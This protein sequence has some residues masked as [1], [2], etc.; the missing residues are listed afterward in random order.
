MLSHFS[1]CASF[2]LTTQ[3]GEKMQLLANVAKMSRPARHLLVKLV[4]PKIFENVV[5]MRVPRG[6]IRAV[7]Q[8]FLDQSLIGV[9]IGVFEGWHAENIIETLNIKTLYLVD[10]Y[11]AYVDNWDRTSSE[12]L[13]KAFGVARHRL[14]PYRDKVVWVKKPSEAAAKN[15]PD[16]LDFVYIDGNHNYEFVKKDVELY[17]PK[18]KEGG[19]LGGHNFEINFMG[20]PKA[21]IEF[22]A[23]KG[24]KLEG[25][26][27]SDWWVEKI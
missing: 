22:T 11:E 1:I 4:A 15:I 2:S 27:P 12:D 10:P 5:S 20:V 8:K 13:T 7:K 19:I 6:M 23:R 21:V 16:D 24:L 14:A 9:E 18:I 26:S 3:L 17:Y 25:K